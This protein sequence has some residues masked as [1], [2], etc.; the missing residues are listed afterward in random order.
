MRLKIL[1]ITATI[2]LTACLPAQKINY[3]KINNHEV[4][5]EL[6]VTSEKQIKGLSQS[7]IL[8]ENSGMLFIYQRYEVQNFWMKDMKFPIDIIWIKDDRIIDLTK[9]IPVPTSTNLLIYKP[10]FPVNYVLE[11]NA[12]WTDKN[13]IQ[14]G[15]QVTFH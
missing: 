3:I 10:K 7:D 8:P 1:A 9:N 2:L 15:D 11:V 14:V 12:G 4:N 13:N 6:A 5:V